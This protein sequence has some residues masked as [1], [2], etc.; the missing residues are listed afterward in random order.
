MFSSTALYAESLE[1]I[2]HH[3]PDP[4][5]ELNGISPYAV[6]SVGAGGSVLLALAA[7][8]P[9][10]VLLVLSA[11]PVLL[12]LLVLPEWSLLSVSDAVCGS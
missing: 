8:F 3:I 7:L 6:S 2:N 12:A 4:L 9:L 10:L 1:S 5:A 11:L